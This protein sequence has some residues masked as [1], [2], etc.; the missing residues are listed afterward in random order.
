M[1]VQLSFLLVLVLCGNC[2][3]EGSGAK[4]MASLFLLPP[5]ILCLRQF[6]LTHT[7]IREDYVP[8]FLELVCRAEMGQR[9][10]Y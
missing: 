3:P 5:A 4:F 1:E 9:D 8:S 7:S 10:L 2:F 6:P